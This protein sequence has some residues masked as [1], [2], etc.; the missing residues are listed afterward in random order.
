MTQ[1]QDSG[2]QSGATNPAQGGTG[3]PEGVS[4][5]DTDTKADGAQS[6]AEGTSGAGT[7]SPSTEELDR[8]REQR[9]L[10]DQR[11]SKAEADLKQLRDK[12]I[13]EMQRMTRD[14]AEAQK[15]IEELK[16]DLQKE[17]VNN[18]F[19]SHNKHAWHNPKR[20]LASL[21]LSGVEIDDKGQVN[22]LE[23]AV[24][25]LAKDEPYMLKPK[26]DGKSGATGTPPA[27]NGAAGSAGAGK[28]T[29]ETVNRFP[30]MRTRLPGG[31]S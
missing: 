29:K 20:A 28:V 12:D 11:A 14:L 10:A 16:T 9:R 27:N 6:G 23:A 2:A 25:R 5:G 30:A 1:P 31:S 19:L 7:E 26:D 3:S 15:T 18:A 22:G 21:D 8:L 4:S 17:R 13:P 24:D